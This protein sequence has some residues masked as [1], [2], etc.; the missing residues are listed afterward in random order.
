M[1]YPQVV[2]NISPFR[3]ALWMLPTV[4]GTILGITLAGV[5]AK[6]IRPG[7]VIGL[8]LLLGAAGFAVV[9]QVQ[10]DS[11]IVALLSGYLVRMPSTTSPRTPRPCPHRGP[12]A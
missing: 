1:R 8:G 2:L 6:R 11:S 9:S 7:F 10:V 3:A 5:L 4:V 12:V